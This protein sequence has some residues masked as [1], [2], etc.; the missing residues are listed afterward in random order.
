[1]LPSF[2]WASP[3]NVFGG[4]IDNVCVCLGDGDD[5]WGGSV[6]LGIPSGDEFSETRGTLEVFVIG[7]IATESLD[8][9]VA[10][11]IDD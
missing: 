7:D 1:M 11:A 9:V 5:G 3:L 4:R 8:N 6:Y 10:V 2:V